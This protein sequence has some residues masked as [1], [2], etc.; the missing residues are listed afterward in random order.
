MSHRI[1]VITV[2]LNA[3]RFL[4]DCLDSVVAQGDSLFEHIIVDGGSTDSTLEIVKKYATT[5]S[6]IRWISEPD[7][8]ISDAMNKGVALATGDIICHLNSDD[9]Y[10]H[11][12]VFS[13]VLNLFAQKP[14]CLWLT[15]G[16]SFVSEN[17][18][19]IRDFRARRYSFRRLVRGNILFHSSTFIKRELFNSVGGFNLSISLCMDYDLFLRLG[20]VISP[21]VVDE[22]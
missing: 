1:S 16:F 22:L 12:Q 15:G 7:R 2:T 5:D 3:G 13:T 9:Y 19:L 21:L 11:P 18:T 6:R 17:G 20:S 8:G 14:A 4:A 10:A